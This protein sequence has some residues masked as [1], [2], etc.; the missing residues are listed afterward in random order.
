MGDEE[1]G[2]EEITW[3]GLLL[4][5]LIASVLLAIETIRKIRRK[6]RGRAQR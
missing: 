5:I 3:L 6:N 2:D 1:P 4:V